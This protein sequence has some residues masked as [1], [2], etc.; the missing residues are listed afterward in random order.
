MKPEMHALEPTSHT[1]RSGTCSQP[2]RAFTLIEL[3]VVIAIIA[4]LA[5]MLL[6]ALGKAKLKAQ[7]VQCVSNLKQVGIAMHLYVDDHAGS[8]PTHNGWADIGGQTPA[9]PH[10]A[11]A[12]STSATNRPLNK[13]SG[14]VAVFKCPTDK[15]DPLVANIMNCYDRYGTSYLV[16]W[17]TAFAVQ[18]VTGASNPI[19][20]TEVARK[21]TTKIIIGDWIWHYNRSVNVPEGAWHNHKGKRNLNMLFGDGHVAV[22][23]LD[24]SVVGVGAPVNLNGLWW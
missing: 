7:A 11:Y 1:S 19:K 24:T 22:S 5:A 12:S 9:N 20:E 10:T 14:N 2:L 3:L 16:Q 4:I 13:Y 23:K 6:P 21:P 8:Y 18:K 15:G 17:A